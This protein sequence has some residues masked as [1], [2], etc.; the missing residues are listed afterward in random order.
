ESKATGTIKSHQS[1]G[2]LVKYQIISDAVYIV[3]KIA[4]A[5]HIVGL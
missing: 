5:M 2:K 1:F 4:S 3:D